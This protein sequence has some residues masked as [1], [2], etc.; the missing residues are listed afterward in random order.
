MHRDDDDNDTAWTLTVV[1]LVI[2]LIIFGTAGI[3]YNLF[4]MR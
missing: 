2:C 3:A 4:G 1:I